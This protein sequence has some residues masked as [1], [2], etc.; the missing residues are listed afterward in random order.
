M[1]PPL[2][3]SA[4]GAQSAL[5]LAVAAVRVLTLGYAGVLILQNT[6]E[7]VR[8]GLGYLVLATMGI[9]TVAAIALYRRLGPRLPL[10]VA[11]L[12]VAVTLVLATVLVETPERIAAG[13][14][15]LPVSWAAA[16]VLAWALARG[17]WGGLGAAGVVGAADLL[18][19]RH[20]SHHTVNNIVLLLMA[21]LVVGW[22]SRLLV[23]VERSQSEAAAVRAAAAERERLARSI[24]DGVL[25][26]LTLVARR[27]RGLPGELGELGLLASEQEAAV[28]SLVAGPPRL[29]GDGL[30]DLRDVLGGVARPNVTVSVPAAPVL[31]PA[32]AAEEVTAATRA[33]LDNVERHVGASA[34]AWV[35]VE[36]EDGE[37][38]VSIRDD[39]PGMRATRPEEAAADGRLGIAQSMRGRLA[40]LGGEVGIRSAP[41]EGTE[42]ELRVPRPR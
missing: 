24:H 20:L 39:G 29:A 5:E 21:G 17:P 36:D 35:L 12:A 7:Y 4:A 23:L 32:H 9:W 10:L 34:P 1:T 11:D 40:A 33:A 41:G 25:Q 38:C 26:V 2:T 15:T 16:P 14:P 18:E 28:R 6:P 31:L 22:I 8:P 42:V 13:A 19:S 30:V 37:V 27:T 3:G